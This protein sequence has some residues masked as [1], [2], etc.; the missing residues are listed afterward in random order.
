MKEKIFDIIADYDYHVDPFSVVDNMWEAAKDITLLIQEFIE[1]KDNSPDIL[2]CRE[3]RPGALVF[4]KPYGDKKNYNMNELF[5][6]W[7][8]NVYKK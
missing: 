6:Y 4:Y 2:H 3:K 5:D 1:W 7:Y 8:N